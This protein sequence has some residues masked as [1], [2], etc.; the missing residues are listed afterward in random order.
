MR[1]EKRCFKELKI[2]MENEANEYGGEIPVGLVH[3]TLNKAIK[4]WGLS[5]KTLLFIGWRLRVFPGEEELKDFWS[6]D[7]KSLNRTFFSRWKIKWADEEKEALKNQSGKL[8][9]EIVV[10]GRSAYGVRYQLYHLKIKVKKEKKPPWDDSELNLLEEQ[11]DVGKRPNEVNI[12][13]RSYFGIK[14]KMR[15]RGYKPE[16]VKKNII[17]SR[18]EEKKL[19]QLVVD[20]GMSARQIEKERIFKGRGKDSIAQKM[21]RMN[22]PSIRNELSRK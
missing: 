20:L 2:F 14:A 3:I 15:R 12:P 16:I 10:P 4:T 13:N 17:W 5:Y 8:I 19:Y 9:E 7:I 11:I 22:L 1:S 6:N 21:R 18:S